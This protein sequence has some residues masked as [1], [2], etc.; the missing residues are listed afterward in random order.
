MSETPV[1]KARFALRRDWQYSWEHAASFDGETDDADTSG[2]S[3]NSSQIQRLLKDWSFHAGKAAELAAQLKEF[4][5]E[6][7]LQQS[8]S[9]Q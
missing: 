6:V 9:S 5:M 8:Q 2:N 7:N 3:N 4:G 1:P